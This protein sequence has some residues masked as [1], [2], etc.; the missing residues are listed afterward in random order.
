MW[1]LGAA[2]GAVRRRP[3]RVALVGQ[4]EGAHQQ[5]DD[6]EAQGPQAADPHGQ[7]VADPA[8]VPTDATPFAVPAPGREPA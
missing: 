3:A 4:H 8:D 1:G 6:G 7:R 2:M 5:V